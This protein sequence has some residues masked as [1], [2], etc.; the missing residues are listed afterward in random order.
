M[1]ITAAELAQLLAEGW[2]QVGFT[3]LVD[4]GQGKFA[5]LL[6]R[7]S[8]LKIIH[9]WHSNGDVRDMSVIEVC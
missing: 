9:I 1:L 7:N 2:N 6:R 4:D 3:E 8:N 5:L